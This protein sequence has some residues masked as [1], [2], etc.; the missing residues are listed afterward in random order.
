MGVGAS[1][2]WAYG[3]SDQLGGIIG[4][5]DFS[6]PNKVFLLEIVYAK[7]NPI[8]CKRLDFHLYLWNEAAQSFEMVF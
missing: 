6:L 2:L 5:K 4:P 1:V 3:R 8:F 7:E